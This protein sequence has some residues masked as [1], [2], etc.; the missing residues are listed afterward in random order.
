[1]KN[2]QEVSGTY[3]SFYFCLRVFV[4]CH[5]ERS[6]GSECMY[7]DV[8]RFFVAL[9]LR[10]TK[11]TLLKVKWVAGRLQELLPPATP[12]NIGC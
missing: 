2:I 12:C 1:M 11:R 9:L 8:F 4:Y 5:S 6:E 10:M 7:V 3:E